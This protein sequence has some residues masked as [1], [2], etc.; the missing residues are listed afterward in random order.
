LRN[1]LSSDSKTAAGATMDP[2]DLLGTWRTLVTTD[3][4]IARSYL[5]HLVEKIVVHDSRV[6][7][8]PRRA[9]AKD[10]EATMSL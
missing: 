6:V 8:V 3:P 1:V 10:T 7:V 9:E 4:E 5:E 2:R